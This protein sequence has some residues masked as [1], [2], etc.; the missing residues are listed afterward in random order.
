MLAP[1][2]E[3]SEVKKISGK[4]IEIRLNSLKRDLKNVEELGR[5]H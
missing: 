2:K 3:L 5:V 4:H 1:K